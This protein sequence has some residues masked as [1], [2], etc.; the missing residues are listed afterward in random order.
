MQMPDIEEVKEVQD[1]VEE[2]EEDDS[3]DAG[4]DED[5]A[6]KNISRGEKK[7]R[8]A[9]S[10]LGLKHIKDINRVVLRRA[11]NNLLIVAQPDVYKS[12]GSDIYIVFGEVKQES[13]NPHV[14][15]A[16]QAA[17]QYQAQAQAQ[18]VDIQKVLREAAAAAPAAGAEDDEE[19]DDEGV[20]PKDIELVMQQSNATR[21]QAVKALKA[22]NND[23][24]NAIMELTL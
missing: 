13:A 20:E 3:D 23:I 1:V 9:L 11:K 7:A 16:T 2:V 10:K 6:G 24:V 8:K 4:D 15:A 19:V 18:G 5:F 12:S 17:Q 21:S 14:A 22:N